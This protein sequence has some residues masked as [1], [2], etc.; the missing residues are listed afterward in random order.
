MAVESKVNISGAILGLLFNVIL[1]GI[2]YQVG[3]N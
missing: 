1:H 3:A 2:Q